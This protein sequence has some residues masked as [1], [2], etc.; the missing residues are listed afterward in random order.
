MLDLSDAQLFQAPRPRVLMVLPLACLERTTIGFRL[1]KLEM[2][3]DPSAVGEEEE[4]WSDGGRR[5]QSVSVSV[6]LLTR[7]K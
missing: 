5:D 2:H 3:F 4:R 6:A 1:Q 7:D